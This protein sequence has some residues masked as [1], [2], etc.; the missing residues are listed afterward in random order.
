MPT[1]ASRSPRFTS[2]L[3][4]ETSAAPLPP[5]LAQSPLTE[6]IGLW[7]D[8][9]ELAEYEVGQSDVSSLLYLRG[10]TADVDVH[11]LPLG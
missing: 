9:A 7:F 5:Q 8:S 6:E 2:T 1:L 4:V 11:S 10:H 3:P